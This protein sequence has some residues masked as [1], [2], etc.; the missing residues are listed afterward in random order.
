V[1]TRRRPSNQRVHPTRRPTP[2]QAPP[3]VRPGLLPIVLWGVGTAIAVAILSAV[4]LAAVMNGISAGN[5]WGFAG[6]MVMLGMAILVCGAK[7]AEAVLNRREP[8]WRP[9]PRSD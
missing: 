6:C 5:R 3:P 1:A 2:A 7:T 4:V 8:G 9:K